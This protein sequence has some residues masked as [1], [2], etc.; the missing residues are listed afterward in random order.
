M[1]SI[2]YFSN[3][4]S[5]FFYF[6]KY[7]YFLLLKYYRSLKI[8][9]F[10]RT[11]DFVNI[12]YNEGGWKRVLE[13]KFWQNCDSLDS[14]LLH[15][16]PTI[17]SGDKQVIALYDNKLC[18]LPISTRQEKYI[19]QRIDLFRKFLP[20]N[21]E[22]CELGCGFG[23]NLFS[24]R[25]HNFQN[26]L[27]GFDISKNS[28]KA[29]NMIN[30][31]FSLGI[32]FEQ[33]DIT[34]S[35][36]SLNLKGKT[37]FSNYVFEQIPHFTRNTLMAILESEPLQVFH[38]EPI[39]ESYKNTFQDIACK[40]YIEYKNYQMTLLS[41]LK[42]MEKKNLIEITHNFRLG[43]APNPLHIPSFIRW[44]PKSGKR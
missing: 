26:H 8:G 25:L 24:L 44:I 14:L 28:I 27:F 7:L 23:Y 12:I 15:N 6:K 37:F 40:K 10:K 29:A 19:S 33:A 31:K 16:Y 43:T 39:F 41:E 42:D 32:K 38:F 4:A 5:N 13:S 34:E 2:H 1:T 18:K 17:G 35:L 9:N 22:V 11:K 3:S 30:D 36:L 20:Q 21:G